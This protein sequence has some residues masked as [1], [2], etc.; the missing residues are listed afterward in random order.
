[1]SGD[2]DKATDAAADPAAKPSAIAWLPHSDD[3]RLLTEL[4]S[5]SND[6]TEADNALD[7]AL[8]AGEAS[9]LWIPL[10]G[11]AIVAYMRAF[12][13]SN[14]RKPLQAASVVP[15][16][17]EALHEKIRV[18]RNATVAHSV[19]ELVRPTPI[20]Y[21]D[22]E[23][24]IR[25]VGDVVISQHLPVE[26]ARA[27]SALMAAVQSRV[28]TWADGI[29]SRLE[30]KYAETSPE[31]IA[32]WATPEV[33]ARLARDFPGGERRGEGSTFTHYVSVQALDE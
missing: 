7:A 25:R 12:G 18:Y 2:D 6:L 17:F 27:F 23:G 9:P 32:G 19:S 28:E 4:S 21:L 5:Y 20:A 24:R 22:D 14:V 15:D 13:H 11:F 31:T 3:A 29:R 33:E 1:M 26:V 16:E 30:E 8:A 10:T